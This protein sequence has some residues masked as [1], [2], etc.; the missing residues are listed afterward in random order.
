LSSV[1]ILNLYIEYLKLSVCLGTNN[2][3][4][5]ESLKKYNHTNCYCYALG[6][7][8]PKLFYDRYLYVEIENFCHNL[9][10]ISCRSKGYVLDKKLENLYRDLETLN[11]IF[12]ETDIDSQNQHGG[13]KIAFY[14]EDSYYTGDFHFFRQNC[15]GLWSEKKGYSSGIVLHDKLEPVV[16]NYKLVKTLEIVKPV[17]K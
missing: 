2:P 9:G 7:D 5:Y 14:N 1:E 6:I 12:Y 8:F 4:F 11:I 10:F 13:Y 17:I 3:V 16:G 15:D